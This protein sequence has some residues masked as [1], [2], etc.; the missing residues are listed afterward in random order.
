M[1]VRTA[2]AT[3]NGDLTD[4][5]GSLALGSGAWEGGYSFSSRF[6]DGAESNPEELIGAAHAGCFA[7]AL[8]NELDGA[9][10]D[11]ET[12]DATAEVTLDKVDGDFSITGIHLDAEATVPDVDEET[13]QEI[14]AGAKE[15]CIV[16]RALAVDITLDA[17]LA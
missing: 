14:A 5:D 2:D 17:T 12:V 8:A 3:W 10:Y 15:N 9:G 16:S 4:G 13:F 7:M 11:P 1:P 6:E